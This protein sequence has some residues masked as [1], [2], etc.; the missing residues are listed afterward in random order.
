M[1]TAGSALRFRARTLPILLA[2][3][4]L[5]IAAGL[6]QNPS[7]AEPEPQ[8]ATAPNAAVV[9]YIQKEMLIPDPV[10]FPN[11]LD[12]IEVHADI[13]G[14]H[15][16]VVLTHG[17]S[18]KEEERA[19]VTPWAQLNQAMWFARRGYVA[20][21]VTRR[22]YGHSGGVRDGTSGGCSSRGGGFKEAGDSSADD[23]RTVIKFG[24]GLPEVDPNT[25]VSIGISTGGFAQ[26]ALSSNPPPGLKAAIDFAGGRGSDGHEHNCNITGLID[27]Y[28]SFGKSAHKHGDLPML[29]I[30]SENDHYFTPAMAKEFQTAYNKSGASE[31]FI[32]A[33]PDRDEGHHL[34]SD[35]SAW[36]DTVQAFL[37]AHNLLPLGDDV[38]PAPQAPSVPAPAGLHDQSLQAWNRFLLG[39]PYKTFASNGQGAWG[40]AQAAFDQQ[41]ADGE[42]I[43]R[44]KKA[45]AGA[46]DCSIVARTPGLK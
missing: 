6:A 29:W 19:H 20:I 41:I 26:V 39:A 44:C 28:V 38:L 23:L 13:P 14:R 8:E 36:S 31:Q 17:T 18:D 42:A 1:R 25:V 3:G 34:Y 21:V 4:T 10:A 46:G 24:Q 33:P 5:P 15:P 7:E 22:G 32:L 40:S 45:A 27:A 11:G 2:V 43:D 35:I 30:Y 9:H 16:L 12:A 37:K